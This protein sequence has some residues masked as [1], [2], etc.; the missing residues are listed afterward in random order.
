[1]Y[2]SECM[3]LYLIPA[4]VFGGF[5]CGMLLNKYIPEERKEAQPYLYWA[6]KILLML[7]VIVLFKEISLSLSTSLFL[8]GGIVVGIFVKEIYFYFACVLLSFEF[9]PA[10]LCFLYGLAAGEKKALMKTV[11]F[12]GLP[13]FLLFLTFDFSVLQIIAT[14]ALLSAIARKA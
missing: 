3:L 12:F 5:L 13:F 6:K 14:G 2:L 11:L 7:L 10:V 4:I 1:M 9:L 8:L